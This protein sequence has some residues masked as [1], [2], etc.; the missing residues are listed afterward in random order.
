MKALQGPSQTPQGDTASITTW[1]EDPVG[2]VRRVAIEV[3][4]KQA[5]LSEE[6][7]QDIVELLEDL[8]KDV[9]W[10]VIEALLN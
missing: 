10:A 3:L 8:Y 9:R 4:Q 7:F 5:N 1:L 2:D 6:M